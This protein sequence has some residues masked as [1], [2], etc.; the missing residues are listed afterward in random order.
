[1]ITYQLENNGFISFIHMVKACN[2]PEK[3]ALEFLL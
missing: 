2:I 1:M 3:E